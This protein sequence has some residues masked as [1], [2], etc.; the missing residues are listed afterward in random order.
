MEGP[1]T[2]AGAQGCG[3]QGVGVLGGVDGGVCVWEE[4]Q[5]GMWKQGGRE[6]D[7]KQLRMLQP[8]THHNAQRASHHQPPPQKKQQQMVCRALDTRSMHT[9]VPEAYRDAA[10]VLAEGLVAVLAWGDDEDREQYRA[11]GCNTET[12]AYWCIPMPM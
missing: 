5:R 11:I 10:R 3:P 2:G 8:Y 4:E 9:P 6:G 1:L 7:M 12:G